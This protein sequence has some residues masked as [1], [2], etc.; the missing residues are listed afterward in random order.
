MTS[1]YSVAA[2]LAWFNI[3]MLVVATLSRKM[4]FLVKYRTSVL[5]ICAVLEV[6]R[7]ALPLDFSFAY[8]ICSYKALPALQKAMNMDILPGDEFMKLGMIFIILWAVGS[9][10][11]LARTAIKLVRESALRRKYKITENQQL[12][13]VFAEMGLKGAKLTVSEDVCVPMETGVFRARIYLPDLALTDEEAQLVIS[14]EYQHFRSSDTLIKAFYLALSV[15]FWWNPVVHTFQRSLDRM[16]E[17]RCDA[18]VTKKMN[19]DGKIAYLSSIL[20]VIKQVNVKR[21]GL[22]MIATTLVGTQ[23][24]TFIKQRF[25]LVLDE[26]RPSRKVQLGAIAGVLIVFL[27]SYTFIVQPASFPPADEVDVGVEITPENAYIIRAEDGSMKLYVDGEHLWDVDEE[28]INDELHSSLPI[29][30]R[31]IYEKIIIFGFGNHRMLS[32]FDPRACD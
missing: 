24:D 4:S 3:A 16:L 31:S 10:A 2:S 32:N 29:Y 14:H 23:A 27:L 1:V 12:S 26:K 7:I 15:L 20:D 17:L 21:S 22:P 5:L 18:A 19:K 25:E 13:R 30:E 9:V 28:M 11:V 6:V 8:V